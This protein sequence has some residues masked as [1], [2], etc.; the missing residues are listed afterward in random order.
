M[1]SQLPAVII[2]RSDAAAELVVGALE[3]DVDLCV[4][5]RWVAD[6]RG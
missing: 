6:P 4:H 1:H 5:R 3:T 2:V